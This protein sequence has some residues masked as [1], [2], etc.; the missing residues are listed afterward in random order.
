MLLG[1]ST[2][3]WI[4]LP[5]DTVPT[6][7]SGFEYPMTQC[8]IPEE[9]NPQTDLYKNFKIHYLSTN[10]KTCSNLNICNGK[11]AV[12]AIV[13]AKYFGLQISNKLK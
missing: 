8:H 7:K 4:H 6:P 3:I 5:T 12:H 11:K 1:I 9:Q 2:S 13:T 10:S